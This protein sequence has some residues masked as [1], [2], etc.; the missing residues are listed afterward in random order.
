MISETKMAKAA[1]TALGQCLGLAKGEK[2][3]ILANHEMQRIGEVLYREGRKLGGDASLLF[4][5]TGKINGEEPPP[6]VSNA[7]TKADVVIA[8][9]VTSITHTK[10]RKRA[11][12]AGARVATMP[13]ITEEIF[14]R[15][16][17]ANYEEIGEL[18]NLLFKWLDKSKIAHMTSP[19]GTDIVLD[20][21]NRACV[22]DGNL[23]AKGAGG[24]LPTGESE[25]APKTADGVIVVDRCGDIITEPTR[26]EVQNGHIVKYEGNPSGKRFKNMIDQ[27]RKIDGSDNASFVAEFAIGTN[28]SAKVTGVILEDE[29]VYG[30]AH[31]AFGNNT[32]YPGGKNPSTLH[33]DVI[34][35]KP[36]ISLDGK[37]IM[38]KGK[39]VI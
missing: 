16:L 36:T 18:C 1:R 9:T 34:I 24:N 21:R 35:F 12:Q 28:K 3:L 27:A 30:T 31:I 11:C 15:G 14:V 13:G 37:M 33:I 26:I 29:K 32:S 4:Y 39:L 2:L 23:R 10:A 22:S 25:L 6:L 8:A 38:K 5:P 7:M 17:G 19:S 20:I